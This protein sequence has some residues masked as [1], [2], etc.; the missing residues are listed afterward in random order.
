MQSTVSRKYSADIHPASRIGSGIY[1]NAGGGIV[2]G[3]TAV[4]GQDVSILQGVTLGGTGTEKKSDRHPKV[5]NGVILAEGSTVLGNIPVGE[6]AF[7]MPKSI[8]TKPVPPLA[9]VSGIPARIMGYRELTQEE[10]DA[11]DL[12]HHL[13]IKYMEQWQ[14]MKDVT[15]QI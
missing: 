14:N 4:V 6:G 15:D 1:L 5:G 9:R 11:D 2:I 7:V 13:G 3:E 10:F 12:E 8:V